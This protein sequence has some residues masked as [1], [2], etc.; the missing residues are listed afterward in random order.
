MFSLLTGVMCPGVKKNAFLRQ[1]NNFFVIFFLIISIPK[2][3]SLNV[4]IAEKNIEKQK[5]YPLKTTVSLL[6]GV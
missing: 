4:A 3:R 6:S 1:K 5:S 2:G